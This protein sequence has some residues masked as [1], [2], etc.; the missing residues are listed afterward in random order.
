VPTIVGELMQR[1][2]ARKSNNMMKALMQMVK[3]DIKRLK[4]AYDEG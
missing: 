3:L 4:E 1:Q 2:D